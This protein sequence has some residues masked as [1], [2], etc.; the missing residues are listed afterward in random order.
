LAFALTSVVSVSWAAGIAPSTPLRCRDLLVRKSVDENSHAKVLRAERR[1]VLEAKSR[2][3][4][5]RLTAIRAEFKDFLD[6]LQVAGTD[7]TTL[8][9]IELRQNTLL[10]VFSDR[11]SDRDHRFVKAF[12]VLARNTNFDPAREMAPIPENW[13]WSGQLRREHLSWTGFSHLLSLDHNDVTHRLDHDLHFLE[14]LSKQAESG[15]R[16][17]QGRDFHKLYERAVWQWESGLLREIPEAA[18]ALTPT[19]SE[20]GT[21]RDQRLA[22][23]FS[24]FTEHVRTRD[25]WW[26]YGLSSQSDLL[27]RDPRFMPGLLRHL[28]EYASPL[29]DLIVERYFEMFRR[30]A[31]DEHGL[32]DRSVGFE[33]DFAHPRTFFRSS[34]QYGNLAALLRFLEDNSYDVTMRVHL[35]RHLDHS[36]AMLNQRDVRLKTEGVDPQTNRT[37]FQRVFYRASVHWSTLA[38]EHFPPER[39]QHNL[40]IFTVKFRKRPERDPRTGARIVEDPY[41]V[42]TEVSWCPIRQRPVTSINGAVSLSLRPHELTSA[43]VYRSLVRYVKTFF[44][45]VYRKRNSFDEATIQK[46]EY[47]EL[48]AALGRLTYFVFT[49]PS[50]DKLTGMFRLFD[51]SE[52]YERIGERLVHLNGEKTFIERENPGLK[53]EERETGEDLFELGRLGATDLVT[54]TVPALLSRVAEN[55]TSTGRRGSVYM[56]ALEAA[57]ELYRKRY[58]ATLRYGPDELAPAPE[59]AYVMQNDLIE[60]IWRQI[61]IN[62]HQ[63]LQSEADPADDGLTRIRKYFQQTIRWKIECREEA[64]CALL[65][66]FFATY[67][68]RF[69]KFYSILVTNARARFAEYLLA[70]ERERAF[71]KSINVGVVAQSL[72]DA[73]IGGLINTI[74]DENTASH[75]ARLYEKWNQLLGNLLGL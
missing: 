4:R 53:F 23:L 52:I 42:E 51:G 61:I 10:R 41:L 64:Q 20:L 65:L 37:P 5:K 2:L 43:P 24:D 66:Y 69:Q 7:K 38:R 32:T 62:N 9:L 25:I 70:A 17:D 3:Q 33:R 13:F 73:V 57:A 68:P 27:T 29:N 35:L 26:N 16:S 46:M 19:R 40:K 54:A 39:Y 6:H 18:A 71:K 12:L 67:E 30:T 22:K 75:E 49:H 74:A 44:D 48:H 58:G 28:R 56:E 21:D 72:H 63:Y 1:H 8:A 31:I 15:A 60:E 45:E 50:G 47:D 36:L 14:F 59:A 11:L 55:F 34:F